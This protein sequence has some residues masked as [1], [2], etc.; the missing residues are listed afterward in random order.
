MKRLVAVLF[1]LGTF[2]IGCGE[3]TPT[4]PAKGPAT[5]GGTAA[6]GGTATTAPVTPPAP[7][8]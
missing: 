5:S 7:A 1:V 8:K 2:A 4:T 3:P 6:S